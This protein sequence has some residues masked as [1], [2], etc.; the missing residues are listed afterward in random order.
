M[1]EKVFTKF[2]T[3][4]GKARDDL[5]E[6]LPSL[7]DPTDTNNSSL[8]TALNKVVALVCKE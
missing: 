8:E 4:A 1:F 3:V 6:V 7:L 5:E 2:N